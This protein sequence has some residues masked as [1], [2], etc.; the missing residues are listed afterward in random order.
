MRVA[1]LGE[2]T[3]KTTEHYKQR[4]YIS[5]HSEILTE[6]AY[7]LRDQLRISTQF[8]FS[9]IWAK[10][11][12]LD[13]HG[14][15]NLE[16]TQITLTWWQIYTICLLTSTRILFIDLLS[17]FYC[18]FLFFY[19]LLQLLDEIPWTMYSDLSLPTIEHL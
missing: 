6:V 19:W 1:F 17:W 13:G 11:Y 18:L 4:N 9:S 5:W 7:V 2:R 16:S 12:I 10:P 8:S 3:M 14:T 15:A